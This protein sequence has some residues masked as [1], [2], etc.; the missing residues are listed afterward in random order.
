MRA[1]GSESAGA[2]AVAESEEEDQKTKFIATTF[3][4]MKLFSSMVQ[5]GVLLSMLLSISARVS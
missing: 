1:Q 4:A 2:V 5:Q 3:E